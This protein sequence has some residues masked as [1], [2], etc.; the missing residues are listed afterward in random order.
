MPT[1]GALPQGPRAT[2]VSSEPLSGSSPALGWQSSPGMQPGA[3]ALPPSS[4][5]MQLGPGAQPQLGPG[6]PS[7]PSPL[8]A[9]TLPSRPELDPINGWR[10]WGWPRKSPVNEMRGGL[11]EL[12]DFINGRSSPVRRS[13]VLGSAG[14]QSA[15]VPLSGGSRGS[16]DF[17]PSQQRGFSGVGYEE[18]LANEVPTMA[19][20]MPGLARPNSM[21]GAFLGPAQRPA[22]AGAEL[23]AGMRPPP[24]AGTSGL[25]QNQPVMGGAPPPAP[26]PARPLTP[27]MPRNMASFPGTDPSLLGSGPKPF[28]SGQTLNM[29]T[30]L[31]PPPTAAPQPQ[32]AAVP[33]GFAGHFDRLL[34]DAR[35]GRPA[36]L[37]ALG[38]IPPALGTAGAAAYNGL[39]GP[40]SAANGIPSYPL[41][42]QIQPTPGAESR[43]E[44]RIPPIGV[45]ALPGFQMRPPPPRKKKKAKK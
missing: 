14:S 2:I 12:M 9:P 39:V 30:P 1:Q 32:G 3:P 17:G 38:L 6:T 24:R 42:E 4:S 16:F 15:R 45:K 36:A 43:S 10:H 34:L 18:Y 21:N 31:A 22:A 35:A 19:N 7:G 13:D 28:P 33:Q 11:D 23:T 25:I 26:L 29:R 5:P 8:R 40:D 37:A 27:V 44:D 41:V 20:S